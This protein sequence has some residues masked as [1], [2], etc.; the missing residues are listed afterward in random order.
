MLVAARAPRL[1][2][3]PSCDL[4][5]GGADSAPLSPARPLRGTWGEHL[6]ALEARAA[7]DR[8][9]VGRSWEG[10]D[11]LSAHDVEPAGRRPRLMSAR[12]QR[13]GWRDGGRAARGA[14][15][16]R[17]LELPARPFEQD[18]RAWHEAS[19]PAPRRAATCSWRAGLRAV[20]GLPSLLVTGG[21]VDQFAAECLAS[22]ATDVAHRALLAL[23]RSQGVGE[24][25]AG[26]GDEARPG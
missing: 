25:D 26:K 20:P 22:G 14:P 6:M 17:A 16:A 3:V 2:T 5:G 18:P 9:D 15:S 12:A 1:A 4:A 7:A 23:Q 19:R 21:A 11:A 24:Q 8:R 10:R 13:G